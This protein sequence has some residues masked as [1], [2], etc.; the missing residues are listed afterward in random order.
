MDK[1]DMSTRKIMDYIDRQDQC[2]M[3]SDI[4]RAY[5][6]NVEQPNPHLSAMSASVGSAANRVVSLYDR[7]TALNGR[8]FGGGLVT[9]SGD[10]EKPRQNGEVA[11]LRAEIDDLHEAIS[12]LTEQIAKLETL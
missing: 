5:A 10:T 1:Q 7:V 3:P 2:V 12:A 9:G 4:G 8:M 11:N 6:N